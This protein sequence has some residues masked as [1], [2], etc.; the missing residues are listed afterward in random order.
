MQIKLK[1]IR[2]DPPFKVEI[3]NDDG[4]ICELT[5]AEI[6]KLTKGAVYY[7]PERRLKIELR[8]N[9]LEFIENPNVLALVNAVEY[10]RSK[11]Y[12]GE[13]KLQLKIT[14]PIIDCEYIY[15][16]CSA[17]FK[18]DEDEISL[19]SAMYERTDTIYFDSEYSTNMIRLN[20]GD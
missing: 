10:F 20:N 15:A 17:G 19:Y 1:R 5:D 4:L 11:S 3:Y 7:G 14:T 2:I 9:Q 6:S 18:F 16:K 8:L 12:T 13:K